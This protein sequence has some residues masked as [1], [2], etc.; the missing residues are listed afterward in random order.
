MSCPK[1]DMRP[2]P[3]P[4]LQC[5]RSQCCDGCDLVQVDIAMKNLEK[6]KSEFRKLDRTK[7]D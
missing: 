2:H 4:I 5:R 1:I 3:V 6:F 7:N